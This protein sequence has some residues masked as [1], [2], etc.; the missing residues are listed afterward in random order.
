MLFE[1]DWYKWLFIF[2]RSSGLC[3]FLLKHRISTFSALNVQQIFFFFR[4]LL[5]FSSSK[6]PSPPHTKNY[7]QDVNNNNKGKTI[8]VTVRGGPYGCET[9]RF[10]HLLDSKLINGGEI[11][12]VTRR[13]LFTSI[14]IPD[15]LISIRGWFNPRAVLLL[16]E[17]GQL[18]NHI[19]FHWNSNSRS[20]GL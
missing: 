15:V 12:S 18:K 19:A 10:P 5:S 3:L 2:G 17:L 20:S 7:Y 13:P 11:V 6:I 1:Q 8:P 9:S 14:K 4:G 16:E